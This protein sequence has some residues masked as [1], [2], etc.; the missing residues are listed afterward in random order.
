M[1][2][3]GK[4]LVGNGNGQNFGNGDGQKSGNARRRT[5][6]SLLTTLKLMA[7]SSGSSEN[8]QGI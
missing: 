8:A 6:S 7:R 1:V 3:A 2:M 4:R 5:F